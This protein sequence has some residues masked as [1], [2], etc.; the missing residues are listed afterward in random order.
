M[1]IEDKA[2]LQAS[3]GITAVVAVFL[4]M[5][6]SMFVAVGCLPQPANIIAVVVLVLL[7]PSALI[8]SAVK[9]EKF[10]TK[11]FPEKGQ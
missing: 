5:V 1:S 3:A 8:F 9:A 2:A 7:T 6:V 10:V 11:H 4:L